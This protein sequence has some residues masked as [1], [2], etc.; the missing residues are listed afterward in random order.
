ME[1]E[2]KM[3]VTDTLSVTTEVMKHA[4]EEIKMDYTQNYHSTTEAT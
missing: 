2:L 4:R 1:I 3:I